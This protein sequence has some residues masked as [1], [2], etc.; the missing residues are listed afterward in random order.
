MNTTYD[1]IWRCFY[2]FSGVEKSS[3]P[4]TD[5]GK[6]I[7][8]NNGCMHYNTLIDK[9]ET[10]IKCDDYMENINMVLDDDRL[11]LLAYCMKYRFLENEDVRFKQMWQ[12]FSNDVGQKFYREQISGRKETLDNTKAEITRLLNNLDNMSY[13][14]L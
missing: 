5:D 11:L 13:L 9:G 14:D 6:Y 7:L 10:K 8:I 2:D 12:P 3:L 4:Q 1:T